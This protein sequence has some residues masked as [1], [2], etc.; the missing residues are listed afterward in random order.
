MNSWRVWLVGVVFTGLAGMGLF[1]GCTRDISVPVSP[2]FVATPVATS[3]PTSTRTPTPTYTSAFTSTFTFTPTL[4]FT[5]TPTFTATPTGTPTFSPT[6]TN[7]NLGGGTS[8]FTF[9]ATLTNT[10][11]STP[12]PTVTNTPAGCV[13]TE[14][15]SYPASYNFPSDNEC[16]TAWGSVAGS[17]VSATV[18]WASGFSPAPPAGNAI[19]AVLPFA[20]QSASSSD[21]V[22]VGMQFPSP[23]ITLYAGAVVSFEVTAIG[24][25]GSMSAQVIVNGAT[26][27]DSGGQYGNWVNTLSNTWTAAAITLPSP[28]GDASVTQIAVQFLNPNGDDTGP[29]TIAISA[30]TIIQGSATPPTSTFTPT[31]VTGYSWTYADGTADYWASVYPATG[32]AAAATALSS[33]GETGCGDGSTYALDIQFVGATSSS[34]DIQSQVANTTGGPP[35]FPINF[36]ALGATGVQCQVLVMADTYSVSPGEYVAGALYVTSTAYATSNSDND[37]FGGTYEGWTGGGAP[38]DLTN[39]TQGTWIPLSLTPSGGNWTT[40]E[41]SIAAIGVDFNLG[42]ASLPPQADFLV[43]DVIIN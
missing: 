24:S 6:P 27:S 43:C 11:T 20:V 2:A 18:G 1:V 35:V 42:A 40:D 29:I 19:T 14:P 15:T 25:T 26:G 21:Y 22:M 12:T 9:T 13:P 37:K 5:V 4:T 32:A 36:E 3:T 33:A 16:F 7:T 10:A 34:N 17:A 8:T 31:P 30:V 28:S 23:G 39:Y 41:S 38:T